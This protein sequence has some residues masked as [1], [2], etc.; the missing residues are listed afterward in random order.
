[1][2]SSGRVYIGTSGWS[3]K[4][5]ARHFYPAGVSAARQFSYY[6]LHFPTVEVNATFYRLPTAAAV[7]AWRTAAPPGFLYAIK[8]SRTVTHY[9]KL[10]PGAKSFRLLVSRLPALEEH[11]GPVLWQLPPK[12]PKNLERLRA[13]LVRLPRGMRHALEFRDESWLA[14]EVFALLRKHHVAHV[15]VSAGFFPRD[16]TLTTDFAYV[17]FHGLEGGSAHDYTRRELLPWA[18]HLRALTRRGVTAYA[19][20]NNDVNVRAPENALMLMELIG[21][22]AVRPR[23]SVETSGL[24]PA[25][26]R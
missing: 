10:L 6:A 20:F 5:W 22:P 16:L 17:R 26:L 15:S 25:P 11:L 2:R 13:F 14:P 23:P 12:F 8:G 19:Y 1:M 24:A 7:R 4:E 21:D 3:Y 9:F 18:R